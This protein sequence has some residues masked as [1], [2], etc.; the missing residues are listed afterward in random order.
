MCGYT[1][2]NTLDN[3]VAEGVFVNRQAYGN[4]AAPAVAGSEFHAAAQALSSALDIGQAI[5][6]AGRAGKAT[7]LISVQA[8]AVVGH[9]YHRL[10]VSNLDRYR[11]G[12]AVGVPHHVV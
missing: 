1:L 8:L 9:G 10:F 7:V 12:A 11:G 2:R 4:L 6:S 3:G 5:A